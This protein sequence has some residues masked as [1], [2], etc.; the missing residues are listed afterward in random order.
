MLREFPSKGGTLALST[1]CC[2]S[3]RL[4]EQSTVVL[5]A[6][7]NAAPPQL[8]TMILFTNWCYTQK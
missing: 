8:I 1:S 3:Y 5:T 2:K 7:D 4:V 6:A